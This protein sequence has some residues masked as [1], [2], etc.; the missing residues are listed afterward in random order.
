MTVY[1]RYGILF[2]ASKKRGILMK[3]K[4]TEEEADRIIN[5]PSQELCDPSFKSH[6]AKVE[7]YRKEF[8]KALGK[9][10]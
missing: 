4:L 9:G 6:F 5:M 7:D 10:K 1:L 2:L 3:T 8:E